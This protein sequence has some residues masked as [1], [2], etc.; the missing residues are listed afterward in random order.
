MNTAQSR[1]RFLGVLSAGAAATVALAPVPATASSALAPAVADASQVDPI[2]AVIAE[3]W[4]AQE[5]TLVACQ[6]NDLDV[7]EDPNK[8]A[9]E[10]RVSAA[11]LPLFTTAPTTVAGAAALLAYVGSDAHETNQD[12]P[13]EPPITVLEYAAGW[14]REELKAAVQR[15]PLHVSVALSSMIGQ[16][17]QVVE[18]SEPDPIYAAIERHRRAVSE[19]SAASAAAD[20]FSD[21]PQYEA[22]QK[23][24]DK[25]N[26][27]EIALSWKLVEIEPTTAAGL[28]ALMQYVVDIGAARLR[29]QWQEGWEHEFHK[30]CLRSTEALIDG[31]ARS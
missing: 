7:D 28:K 26:R 21:H 30:A 27:K 19:L 11:E 10:N 15:F 4:A 9:A 2:F 17:T 20:V 16:Q 12:P 5:A 31:S 23:P 18:P 24:L 25:A 8:E 13:D 6:A 1:R 22:L 29:W 14:A 3:H